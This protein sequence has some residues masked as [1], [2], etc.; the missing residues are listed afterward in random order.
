MS[1]RGR[2]PWLSWALLLL[3]VP[4]KGLPR[5]SLPRG[6][7]LGE[8]G[9]WGGSG[10]SDL[11]AGCSLSSTDLDRWKDCTLE[12]PDAALAIRLT[13]PEPPRGAQRGFVGSFG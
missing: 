10:R 2:V 6:G 7:G 8:Q 3:W 5:L 11:G 13:F 12:G 9:C 4:G 1:R